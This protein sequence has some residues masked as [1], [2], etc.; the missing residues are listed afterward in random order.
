[1]NEIGGFVVFMVVI[2]YFVLSLKGCVH[3]EDLEK[4]VASQKQFQIDD[5]TYKCQRTNKLEVDQ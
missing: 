2:S 1:M 3:G 5:A 4:H